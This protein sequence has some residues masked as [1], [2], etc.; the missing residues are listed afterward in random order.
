MTS[1]DFK[2]VSIDSITV[3]RERRQRR[4]LN[5]IDELAASISRVGLINP[6]VIRRDGTL[7]AGERRYT[8]CKS[9]G[10]TSIPVQYIEDLPEHEARLIE[11]EENIRRVDLD[12]KDQCLAVQE[13]HELRSSM[14][15]EWTQL[16][17]ADVIGLTR[18][19]IGQMID[20]A[21]ELVSG[22]SRVAEAP[23]FSVARGIVQRQ[24][25]RRQTAAI[26]QASSIPV[27]PSDEGEAEPERAPPP[28]INEDFHT[29][30][31]QYA[32]EKFNFIHCD[33]P[34]G[35]DADEHDQG[36][37]A[38]RGGYK[39]DRDTYFSLIETL[40]N[41]LDNFCTPSAHLMFWFSMEYY[42]ETLSLLENSGW[43]VLRHPLIWFKSDNSGI[44][45]DHR[46]QPRRIYETAFMCA[47]GDRYIV[48]PVA[49][50]TAQP[51]VKS[52]HMSEKPQ[53]VLRHFFRMFVDETACVLD[54]TCGSGNA[55]KVAQ[56]MGAQRVLGIEADKEFYDL[57]V[58][59]WDDDS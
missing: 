54:P 55:L 4:S 31:R 44:L 18:Q 8:A 32:G 35:I 17:T 2:S 40:C 11:L 45:P 52:V 25:N 33:F 34:Y 5:G 6:L 51:N 46:R 59:A 37:A 38:A 47:R 10:W 12:W 23:K 7:V 30:A 29:W 57:A 19:A 56:A 49:N 20:V 28:L 3:D 42:N 15:E 13:Y 58:E 53:A 26:K 21:K 50:A 22:N 39:D 24:A 27:L 9:L 36:N 43:R 48:G 1:G 14:A 41:N 16:Q